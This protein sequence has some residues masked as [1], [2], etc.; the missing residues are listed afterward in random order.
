MLGKVLASGKKQL[1]R[2]ELFQILGVDQDNIGDIA[3]CISSVPEVK[4]SSFCS[5][6]I[7]WGGLRE[8]FQGKGIQLKVLELVTIN[9][10]EE[11]V[12]DFSRCVLAI[13]E[14]KLE[15]VKL[16]ENW[17][18]LITHLSSPGTGLDKLFLTECWPSDLVV[19]RIQSLENF[20]VETEEGEFTL[21][22]NCIVL[23]KK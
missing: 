12:D 21:N 1:R 2:L 4:L 15:K 5:I 8:A 6:S 23:T 10:D 14:V 18:T 16:R 7:F 22:N 11:S 13:P 20:V 19:E 17:P 3:R 9:V